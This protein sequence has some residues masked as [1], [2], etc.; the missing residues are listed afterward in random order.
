MFPSSPGAKEVPQRFGAA[1]GG[2]TAPG[3]HSCGSGS[4]AEITRRQQPGTREWFCPATPSSPSHFVQSSFLLPAKAEAGA[5]AA[6]RRSG[7][8]QGQ[9]IPKLE[10][11]KVFQSVTF[12][13]KGCKK[14]HAYFFQEHSFKPTSRSGTLLL[15]EQVPYHISTKRRVLAEEKKK[16]NTYLNNSQKKSVCLQIIQ[17]VNP[18]Q[19]QTPGCKEPELTQQ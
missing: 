15:F 2:V 6:T 19:N 3:R 8:P 9:A 12:P 11:L 10:L 13:S 17:E 1:G 14:Q 5:A 7:Q 18:Q 16:K 4:R